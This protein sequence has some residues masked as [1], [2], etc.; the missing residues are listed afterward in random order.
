[1][2]GFVAIIVL[3]LIASG[4]HVLSRKYKLPYT[5][6]LFVVGMLLIPLGY[7]PGFSIG[8]TISLTPDILF[9]IFLP[10]LIFEA[11]YSI[12]YQDISRD[13]IA[14]WLLATMGICL[15]V[16]LIS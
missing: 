12:K 9:Y 3:L 10:I 8:S 6:M 14:I 15:S 2:E 4:V 11:G 13:H 16:A 1:M 5:I 7:I